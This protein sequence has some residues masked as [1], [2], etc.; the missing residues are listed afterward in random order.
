MQ[1]QFKQ[2]QKVDRKRKSHSPERQYKI[3]IRNNEMNV[4]SFSGEIA[5]LTL[6]RQAPPSDTWVPSGLQSDS[7][8][9]KIFSMWNTFGSQLE[10]DLISRKDLFTTVNKI[11]R[12]Y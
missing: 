6:Q 8:K 5:Y 7:M 9:S 2:I 12:L 10:T 11:Q 4:N 1:Q 3:I